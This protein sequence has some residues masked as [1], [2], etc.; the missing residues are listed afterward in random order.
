MKFG[1]WKCF[2][3]F[4]VYP[5][6]AVLMLA[7]ALQHNIY[8]PVTTILILLLG[9][10]EWMIIEYVMHRFCFHLDARSP[11]VR[12]VLQGLHLTHHA[13]TQDMK[14]MFVPVSF[15]LALTALSI[16]LRA[17]LV[18]SWQGALI[19]TVGV[20]IGYL[21]YEFVHYSAHMRRPQNRLLR[22]L[23]VYHLKHHFQD[24]HSWFGVTTPFIDYLFRTYRPITKQVAR[25]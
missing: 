11:R 14:Y 22:Y 16:W 5:P 9:L 25:N 24:E 20:W 13:N 2:R 21:W 8:A 1:N 23:K 15:G 6:L 18:W 4:Y 19:V 17:L 10:V 3:P 12:A 7:Y